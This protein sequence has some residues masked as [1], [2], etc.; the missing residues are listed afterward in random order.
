[1]MALVLRPECSQVPG[2]AS[3]CETIFQ[4]PPGYPGKVVHWS[5]VTSIHSTR[6]SLL[7]LT[8]K[9]NHCGRQPHVSRAVY[10]VCHVEERPWSGG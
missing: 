6:A 4:H 2:T 7:L 1:M 5:V 3:T 9:D 10:T 8:G